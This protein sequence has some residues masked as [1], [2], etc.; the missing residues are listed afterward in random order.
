M[1][2]KFNNSLLTLCCL[3]IMSCHE[4]DLEEKKKIIEESYLADV[5]ITDSLHLG[6]LGEITFMEDWVGYDE[7]SESDMIREF[8]LP[9]ES[10]DDIDLHIRV[11]M[12]NTLT[13]YLKEMAPDLSLL[14]YINEVIFSFLLS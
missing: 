1:L 13:N 7:Y 10:L 6:H 11:F 8:D 5:V 4:A 3:S 2:T 14:D 9:I 12:G